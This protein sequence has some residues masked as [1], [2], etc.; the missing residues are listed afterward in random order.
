MKENK[1]QNKPKTVKTPTPILNRGDQVTIRGKN[2]VVVE[3]IDT[4]RFHV[5]NQ[6][7]P[8]DSF[9]ITS[10]DLVVKNDPDAPD[11]LVRSDNNFSL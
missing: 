8:F 1:M 5:K 6:D 3:V 4:D 11:L 10:D 9:I 2:T 7:T